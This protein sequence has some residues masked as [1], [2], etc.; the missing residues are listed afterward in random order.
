MKKLML[1]QLTVKWRLLQL[2]K[3]IGLVQPLDT[4]D[5]IGAK[6]QVRI[7]DGHRSLETAVGSLL[8]YSP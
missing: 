2:E 4:P 6:V 1:P 7:Q 5:L 3:A 8:L